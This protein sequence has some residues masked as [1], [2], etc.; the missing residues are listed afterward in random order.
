MCKNKDFWGIALRARNLSKINN[1]ILQ[2]QNDMQNRF[3]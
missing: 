3:L 1:K 2:N